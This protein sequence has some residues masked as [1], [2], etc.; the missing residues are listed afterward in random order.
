MFENEDLDCDQLMKVYWKH[1]ASWSLTVC[2]VMRGGMA[3]HSAPGGPAVAPESEPRVQVVEE[4]IPSLGGPK[5]KDVKPK[6][7]QVLEDELPASEKGGEDSL[8]RD[9]WVLDFFS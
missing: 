1:M 3:A 8:L 6:T 4:S 5:F 9:G 7:Y 2:C